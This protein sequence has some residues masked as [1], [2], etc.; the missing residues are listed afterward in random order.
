MQERKH[1]PLT[2]GLCKGLGGRGL[3]TGRALGEGSDAFLGAGIGRFS[4][5][6]VL[7]GVRGRTP[8]V[9]SVAGCGGSSSFGSSSSDSSNGF[10]G[11]GGQGSICSFALSSNSSLISSPPFSFCLTSLSR[12]CVFGEFSDGVMCSLASEWSGSAFSKLPPLGGD[13]GLAFDD[14]GLSCLLRSGRPFWLFEDLLV[15][16]CLQTSDPASPTSL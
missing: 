15:K 5:A 12:E 2:A 14:T 11:L 4:P 6:V 16:W 9:T 13:S 7:T 8:L 10:G 1:P 3:G